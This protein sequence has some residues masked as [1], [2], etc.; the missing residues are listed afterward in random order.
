MKNISLKWKARVK[1]PFAGH[2]LFP[3]RGEGDGEDDDDDDDGNEM[4]STL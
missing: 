4:V 1:L 3:S 2:C